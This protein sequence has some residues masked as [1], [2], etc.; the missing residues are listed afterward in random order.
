[1]ILIQYFLFF[2]VS[3]F[4]CVEHTYTLTSPSTIKFPNI[5]TSEGITVQRLTS[6]ELN[7]EFVCDVPGLYHIYVEIQSYDK[8][9]FVK[10]SK[11]NIELMLSYRYT[12][13][14]GVLKF[15][16]SNAA[17]VLTKLQEGDTI[18]IKPGEK[19]MHI[20]GQ[21]YSHITIVKVT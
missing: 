19:I 14:T 1:M 16:Y 20:N 15:T 10:I 8:Y 13:I 11:N 18:D 7:G 2:S 5:K 6:F 21:N 12:Y 9:G 3:L 17:F 4:G